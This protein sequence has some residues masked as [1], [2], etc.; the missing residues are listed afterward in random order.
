MCLPIF[1]RCLN[2]ND[3]EKLLILST[4]K[5]NCTINS[6]LTK[7]TKFVTALLPWCL[8]CKMLV[9]KIL[10]LSTVKWVCNCTD[11]APCMSNTERLVS[12]C[13]FSKRSCLA[14]SVALIK[15]VLWSAPLA[16]MLQQQVLSVNLVQEELCVQPED[17]RHTS[18]VLMELIQIWKARVTVHYV[19]QASDVQVLEWKHQKS[20]RMEHTATP[21]VLEIVFCVLKVIGEVITWVS[22]WFIDVLFIY[23]NS[24][25]IKKTSFRYHLIIEQ[26]IHALVSLIHYILRLVGHDIDKLHLSSNDPYTSRF[27]HSWLVGWLVRSFI[28]VAG[29]YTER[30]QSHLQYSLHI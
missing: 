3:K 2:V 7:D 26:Y 15:H 11:Q 13:V 9:L 8:H 24:L 21:M 30:H 23:S 4:C 14:I 1:Y 5:V 28:H 12:H 18:F 19:I 27:I 22:S 16:I 17:L 25:P 29:C 10:H 6:N 20:V